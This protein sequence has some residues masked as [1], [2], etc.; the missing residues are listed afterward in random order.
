M[1]KM[2]CNFFLLIFTTHTGENVAVVLNSPIPNQTV[3]LLVL[4]PA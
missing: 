1:F 3:H 4:G 2:S